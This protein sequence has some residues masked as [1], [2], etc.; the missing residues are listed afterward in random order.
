MTTAGATVA[1][2][3]VCAVAIGGPSGVLGSARSTRDDLRSALRQQSRPDF[4]GLVER[5]RREPGEV[6]ADPM[7][8]LVL[9]GRPVLF[10]PFIYN[11]LLDQGLWRPDRVLQRI[12]GGS[13]GLAV[14]SYS[15][16]VA[17]RMT[18]GLHALWPPQVIAALG[19]TMA[20]EGMEA[21]RYVYTPRLAPRAGCSPTID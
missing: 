13:V 10:E 3:L 20:F 1:L 21:N 11:I 6:I 5:V 14:F 15:L 2:V 12:C 4:E 18:D 7:D 19:D 8:V 17:A 16:E 9:A